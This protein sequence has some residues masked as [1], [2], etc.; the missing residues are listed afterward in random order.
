M[1]DALFT[2]DG[3]WFVPSEHTRG[4]WDDRSQHAGAPSALIGRALERLP[5]DQAMQIVR[6]TIEVLRPMPLVPLQISA[7]IDRPGRRVQ[8]LSAALVAG[9]EELCL[10][11]AWR[12]RVTDLALPVGAPPPDVPPPDAGVVFEAERDVPGFHRTGMEIRFVRGCFE[13]PGN[14]TAWFR[15]HHPVVAGETPSPLQRVL[16]AADFGNGISAALPFLN[17]VFINTDL[18]VHLHRHPVGEW[19]C[20]DAA[21]VVQP[22]GI[23]LAESALSDIEGPIGRSLQSLLVDRRAQPATVF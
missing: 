17:H 4:P 15:L 11:R 23:G 18:T 2:Q 3:D 22:A 21:S 16:A 1:A 9:D 13:E 20:L 7:R 10:A 8:L 5:A 6:V 14:A 12:I 19:I